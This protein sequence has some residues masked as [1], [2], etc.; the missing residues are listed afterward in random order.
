MPHWEHTPTGDRP[1]SGQGDELRGSGSHRPTGDLP[2]PMPP[3]FSANMD[4]RLGKAYSFLR[5]ELADVAGNG[6]MPEDTD[7]LALP[8]EHRSTA[9]DICRRAVEMFET[10]EQEQARTI[11]REGFIDLAGHLPRTWHV[12]PTE[13]PSTELLDRIQGRIR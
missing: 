2:E 11:A 5:R 8:A 3:S 4:E 9:K 10:G 1:R 6:Q 13:Y 12:P 7:F